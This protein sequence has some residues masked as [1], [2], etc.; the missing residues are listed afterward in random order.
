MTI[1]MIQVI[2]IMIVMM[3]FLWRF[4]LLEVFVPL[5]HLLNYI[6]RVC[7][8]Y[9]DGDDDDENDDDNDDNFFQ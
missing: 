4:V 1:T 2:L 5:L 6:G 7:C 3:T 8:M 9:Q